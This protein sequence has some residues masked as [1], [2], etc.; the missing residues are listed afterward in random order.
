[1]WRNRRGGETRYRPVTQH[2][3][4]W[5][6]RWDMSVAYNKI[7]VDKRRR[8]SLMEQCR[9]AGTKCV[10]F[11]STCGSGLKMKP[12]SEWCNRSPF[13]WFLGLLPLNDSWI[14]FPFSALNA[15]TERPSLGGAAIRSS[16][17]SEYVNT[18]YCSSSGMQLPTMERGGSDLCVQWEWV[19]YSKPLSNM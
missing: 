12:A 19:V 3:S 9:S 10:A 5:R 17:Q 11:C 6:G 18:T 14:V 7:G 8:P 1:M 4:W 13:S 16:T 15:V 2:R